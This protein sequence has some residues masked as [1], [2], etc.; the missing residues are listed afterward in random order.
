MG[1]GLLIEGSD[2]LDEKSRNWSIFADVV[3]YYPFVLLKQL[4]LFFF[5]PSKE[6]WPH[7]TEAREALLN[8]GSYQGVPLVLNDDS[9]T[10][11]RSGSRT[12]VATS[13]E[14]Q[15]EVYLFIYQMVLY[16]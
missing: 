7:L 15:V 2:V 9:A 13:M 3:M 6:K 4:F 16:M 11:L 10:S 14:Q 8:E 12:G 5:Q 1:R